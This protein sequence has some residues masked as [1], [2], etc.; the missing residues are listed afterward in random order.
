MLS[1]IDFPT[2]EAHVEELALYPYAGEQTVR[3]A[4]YPLLGLNGE[5][6]ELGDKIAS[7]LRDGLLE[8]PLKEAVRRDLL[9]EAGDYLW[10]LTRSAVEFGSSLE[11]LDAHAEASAPV[12]LALAAL[13]LWGATG[14]VT[15]R[16]KKAL[17]GDD[18]GAPEETGEL[19][20]LSLDDA[21]AEALRRDLLRAYEAL[22]SLLAALEA[23]VLEVAA[24][25]VEKLD[26]R[27]RKNTLRGDGDH[28]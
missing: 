24:L 27:R 3:S 2:Y 26:A 17:R 12:E 14:R 4:F 20:A 1:P 25:N 9:L 28:R 13:L 22:L 23:S 19:F 6:G 15:E 10:Y 21:R 11:E 7:F 18:E 5:G 16:F 8:H